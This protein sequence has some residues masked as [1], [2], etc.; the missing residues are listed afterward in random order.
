MTALREAILAAAEDGQLDGFVPRY[1]GPLAIHAAK[2]LEA[3]GIA[4]ELRALCER[5]FGPDWPNA[6]PRGAIVATAELAGV[7]TTAR[8]MHCDV[9]GATEFVCGNYAPGRYAWQLDKVLAVARTVP[10]RGRQ[11]LFTVPNEVVA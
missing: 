5:A 4:D 9:I 7:W 1:R 8:A 2:R 11:G 3:V 6:L 10:Y